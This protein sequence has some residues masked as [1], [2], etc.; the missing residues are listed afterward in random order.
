MRQGRRGN[1]R[2]DGGG[3]SQPKVTTVSRST[4]SG[5]G[6]VSGWARKAEDLE[7]ELRRRQRSDDSHKVM[8]RCGQ[9]A[10]AASAILS[11]TAWW[12][13]RWQECGGA[14]VAWGGR[15]LSRVAQLQAVAEYCLRA[16]VACWRAG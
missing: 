4:T 10:D 11:N 15:A 2:E 16:E 9:A 6:S 12:L 13:L 3:W 1:V 5:N 14:A 7:G 8:P